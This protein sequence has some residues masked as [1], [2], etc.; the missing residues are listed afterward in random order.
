MVRKWGG[1]RRIDVDKGK[2][3]NG[4]GRKEAAV[5]WKWKESCHQESCWDKIFSFLGGFGLGSLPPTP[6]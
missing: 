6:T 1:R 2:V 5:G 3:G 4:K